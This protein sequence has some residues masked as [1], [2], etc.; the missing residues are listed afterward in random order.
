MCAG[1]GWHLPGVPRSHHNWWAGQDAA[2]QHPAP[3]LPAPGCACCKGGPRECGQQWSPMSTILTLVSVGQTWC[4][5]PW[6]HPP[7]LEPEVG[8]SSP[9]PP[10]AGFRGTFKCYTWDSNGHTNVS[11]PIHLHHPQHMRM[12][13]VFFLPDSMA[14]PKAFLII[15][16]LPVSVQRQCCGL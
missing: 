14:L 2:G 13:H 10:M 1:E 15:M 5:P 3:S 4:Q 11:L 7:A 8:V 9:L 12:Q 6:V 16:P